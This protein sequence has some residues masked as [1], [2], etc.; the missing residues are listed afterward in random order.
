MRSLKQTEGKKR[1]LGKIG[2]STAFSCFSRASFVIEGMKYRIR[3]SW[4]LFKKEG[5]KVMLKL[6]KRSVQGGFHS[7]KP[8]LSCTEGGI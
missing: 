5:W 7:T 6:L 1:E 2:F 3:S 4:P 8:S